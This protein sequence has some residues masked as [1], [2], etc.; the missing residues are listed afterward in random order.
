[1]LV[2]PIPGPV[3][4][5]NMLSDPVLI[6]SISSFGVVLAG[7]A[8]GIP[9]Y[10]AYM[11]LRIANKK[12]ED[13]ANVQEHVV[14]KVQDVAE[15]QGVMKKEQGALHILVNSQT[16]HTIKLEKALSLKEG[17]AEANDK[18]MAAEKEVSRLGGIGAGKMEKDP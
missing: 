15:V 13:L 9:S 5:T 8:A 11:G 16:E 2:P 14:S 7:I 3:N 10:F 4:D 6:A 12:L 17:Q 18:L 1:M